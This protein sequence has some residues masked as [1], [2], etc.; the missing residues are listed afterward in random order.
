MSEDNKDLAGMSKLCFYV[1]SEVIKIF[2]G[3]I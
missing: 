3:L 2:L 1:T